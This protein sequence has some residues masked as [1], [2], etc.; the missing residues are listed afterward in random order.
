MAME[1]AAALADEL[2][3]VE[4]SDVEPAI[5]LFTCRRPRI[6]AAQI[7]SRRLARL[8]LLRSPLLASL[9]NQLLRRQGA[10]PR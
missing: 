9:R 6:D 3:R 10:D 7:G 1:S 2:S 4:A 5:R 8:T